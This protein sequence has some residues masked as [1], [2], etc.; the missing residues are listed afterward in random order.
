MGPSEVSVKVSATKSEPWEEMP[1]FAVRVRLFAE[2]TT[3]EAIV[4]APSVAS[5]VRSVEGL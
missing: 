1:F 2:R 5:R 3:P 4:I